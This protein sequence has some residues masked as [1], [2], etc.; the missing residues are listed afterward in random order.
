MEVHLPNNRL[1][2][3]VTPSSLKDEHLEVLNHLAR[4]YE[5]MIRHEGYSNISI[6][7]K[8][9]PGKKKKVVI[10]AG[11]AYEFQVSVIDLKDENIERFKVIDQLVISKEYTG[12][13]RRLRKRRF[14]NRRKNAMS[15]RSFKLEKRSLSDRRKNFMR[16]K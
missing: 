7:F 3:S 1:S 4:L 10:N 9:L 13:E 5:D 6:C 15:S 16:R 2:S 14:N 11:C 12:A 8:K